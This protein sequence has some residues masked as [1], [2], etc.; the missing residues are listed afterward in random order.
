MKKINLIFILLSLQFANASGNNKITNVLMRN[1]TREKK[2]INIVNLLINKLQENTVFSA[3]DGNNFFSH[4][5]LEFVLF[6]QLG[7][8]DKAGAWLKPKPK[9]SY[10]GELI[11]INRHLIIFQ[12]ASSREYA[13]TKTFC[14]RNDKEK[15][16]EYLSKTFVYVTLIWIK[17]GHESFLCSTKNNYKTITFEVMVNP[18][19]TKAIIDLEGVLINGV[20]LAYLLGFRRKNVSVE[21]PTGKKAVPVAYLLDKNLNALKKHVRAIK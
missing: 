20:P 7:Y 3:S 19:G 5:I 21:Y 12:K 18:K 9:I 8:Q 13:A 14:R 11:R 1:N 2:A 4:S 16:K 10:I 15:Y 17:N 6:S